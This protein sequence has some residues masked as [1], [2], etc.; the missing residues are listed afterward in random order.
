M[1]VFVNFQYLPFVNI[2]SFLALAGLELGRFK[3]ALA[4]R[5]L[6]IPASQSARIKD[7]H[8]GT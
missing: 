8:D 2:L 3:L 4:F 5:D 1:Y 6:P 7:L